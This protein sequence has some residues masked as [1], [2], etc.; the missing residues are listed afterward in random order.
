MVEYLSKKRCDFL[1]DKSY[2]IFKNKKKT[3]IKKKLLIDVAKIL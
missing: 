2:L 3:N 1:Q